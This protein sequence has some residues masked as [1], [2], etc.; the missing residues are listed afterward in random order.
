MD[1]SVE[2]RPVVLAGRRTER[3]EGP[4]FDAELQLRGIRI[5]EVVPEHAG[6]RLSRSRRAGG[7]PAGVFRERRRL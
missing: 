7:M 1:A 6:K 2:P 5:A 3:G 4:A